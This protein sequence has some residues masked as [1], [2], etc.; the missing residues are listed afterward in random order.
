MKG[1]GYYDAHSEYQRRVVESGDAA[2]RELV[3]AAD[4][5]RARGAFT[6]ADYGAGTGATSAD[7]VRVALQALRERDP[8]RPAAAIHNDVITNDFNAVFAAVAAKD[9]YLDLPGAPVYPLAAAGSFFTQVLPDGTVDLGL[10]SNASHWFRDQPTVAPPDSMWFSDAPADVRGPLAEQA[11]GDW[12]AFLAARAAELARGGRMLVQGIGRT[13]ADDGT[14]QVSAA[15]LLRVMWEVAS[16][17]ADDGKLDHELLRDYVFA[18]YCRSAEEATAPAVE[19]GELAGELE[20]ASATVDEV[21][22][23]YWEVLQRDGDRE[24][25]AAAYTA[26]VRAFSE[27]T[28][29][30]N[31]FGPAARGIEPGKLC[32]EYFA[33]FEAATAA[34]PDAGRYEAWI[35]RV[36]YARS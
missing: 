18:A 4:L 25:Y 6:V 1:E 29:T 21:A 27:S 7:A 19:G 13:Q 31:L 33:R 24:A 8:D 10:C 15:R 2:I 16:T 30:L 14:E 26:F 17:L 23:P 5:D 36:A 12:S 34:N 28:L 9:G 35:L 32:D 20:A 11:A 22:N 3:G